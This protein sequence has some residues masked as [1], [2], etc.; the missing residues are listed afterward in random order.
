MEIKNPG[1]AFAIP[2]IFF[3]GLEFACVSSF[4]DGNMKY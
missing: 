4:L 2:G 1:T 3:A